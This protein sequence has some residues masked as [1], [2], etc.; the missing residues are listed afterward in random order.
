MDTEKPYHNGIFTT[1]ITTVGNGINTFLKS[2]Y[3][4]CIGSSKN[5]KPSNLEKT[6]EE[7]SETDAKETLKDYVM[8]EEY[9]H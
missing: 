7:I 1:R 5:Q 3:N 4:L 6:T 8:G 9:K 2:F